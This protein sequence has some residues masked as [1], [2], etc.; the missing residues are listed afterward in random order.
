M[1]VIPTSIP[2]LRLLEPSVFRDDRGEFIESFH[3]DQMG[4]LIGTTHDWVQ[5]NQSIS[6]RGVLRG[7][8]FQQPPHAQAKLVR[9]AQGLVQDVAVDLRKGS[10][11]YG[12]WESVI[13]SGENKRQFYIPEGFAH[14]FLVLEPDTIFCYKC[15]A[16]YHKESEGSLQWNDPAVGIQ[17][18]ID[19]PILSA[20]DD[21]APGLK[22][23]EGT[24]AYDS[25]YTG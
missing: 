20:K 6:K 17:W 14:G 8:H 9:V 7:M 2:D 22:E 3:A 1:K 12:Q 4:K 21:V 18:E 19:N 10:P 13:L 23:L 25:N 16:Y 5:D 15:S 24:F 11:T